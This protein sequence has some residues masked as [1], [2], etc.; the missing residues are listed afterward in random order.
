LCWRRGSSVVHLLY[1]GSSQN[2]V[3]TSSETQGLV[4]EKQFNILPHVG[5]HACAFSRICA[6][7]WGRGIGKS[8]F[9]DFTYF[10]EHL[11]LSAVTTTSTKAWEICPSTGNHR[12]G[13]PPPHPPWVSLPFQ[14]K[15]LQDKPSV[16]L[17]YKPPT[18]SIEERASKVCQYKCNAVKSARIPSCL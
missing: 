4:P 18:P 1:Y 2:A 16:T 6:T 12:G 17:R 9:R 14:L 7:N 13:V 15:T 8:C 11:S 10:F 5:A 3:S